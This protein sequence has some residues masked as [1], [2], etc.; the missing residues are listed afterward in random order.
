MQNKFTYMALLLFLHFKQSIVSIIEF[1]N[2]NAA[3]TEEYV[4]QYVKKRLTLCLAGR[5]ST[6]Q[7]KNCT[8]TSISRNLGYREKRKIE[9]KKTRPETRR[10]LEHGEE[11]IEPRV[12]IAFDNRACRASPASIIIGIRWDTRGGESFRRPRARSR[13]REACPGIDDSGAHK[14][15]RA[16]VLRHV[17]A[18]HTHARVRTAGSHI[19]TA[20][21]NTCIGIHARLEKKERKPQ[22]AKENKNSTRCL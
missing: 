14:H 17:V 10:T 19:G 6:K 8:A 5:G 7:V 4:N 16:D 20:L 22:R 11:R 15:A 9:R 2:K 13:E 3:E 18:R 21:T 12:V 1:K